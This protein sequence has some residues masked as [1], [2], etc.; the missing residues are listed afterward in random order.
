MVACVPGLPRP[1]EGPTVAGVGCNFAEGLLHK[2]SAMYVL[3]FAPS[4]SSGCSATCD[5]WEPAPATQQSGIMHCRPKVGCSHQ[6]QLCL[7]NNA[8]PAQMVPRW[9]MHGVL[10]ATL[11]GTSV[12]AG[13]PSRYKLPTSLCRLQPQAVNN[14]TIHNMACQG[15]QCITLLHKRLPV[16]A[17]A[18]RIG[19]PKGHRPPYCI[20]VVTVFHECLLLA[21]VW[22]LLLQ[23]LPHSTLQADSKT[24]RIM[25]PCRT[26]HPA[27][28]LSKM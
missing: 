21:Y 1:G 13:I 11:Q 19:P 15:Q 12:R 22:Q 26:A 25:Q 16:A 10:A 4:K 7:G 24:D 9:H 2:Q 14:S 17:I 8:C 28:L 6:L 3:T 20:W 5:S 27:P 18:V 23:L